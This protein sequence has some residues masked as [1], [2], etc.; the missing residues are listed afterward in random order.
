MTLGE[1]IRAVESY[2]RV[3]RTQAQERATFDYILADLIG[4]SVGR[5]YSSS[6]EVPEISA[7]YPSLFVAEDIQQK[8]QEKKDEIS[9]IRFKQFAESFN[10]RFKQK[11]EVAIVKDE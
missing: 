6:V 7:V 10:N 4:R 9:A 3:K 5:V 1:I 2:S 11:Q 8:R